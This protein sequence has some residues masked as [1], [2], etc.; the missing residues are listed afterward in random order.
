LNP[1][2]NKNDASPVKRSDS[3]AGIFV[4]DI[5]R[6]VA[7]PYCAM[8][9]ADLGATVIKIE[10]PKD[11][12]YVRSCRIPDDCIDSKRYPLFMAREVM[13]QLIDNLCVTTAVHPGA[14]S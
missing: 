5:T 7:G 2:I 3:L 9:L 6:V 1:P 10:H 13:R 11:A 4:L 14:L 12:D 8:M